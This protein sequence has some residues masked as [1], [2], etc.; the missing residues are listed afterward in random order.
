MDVVS[1][2]LNVLWLGRRLALCI[3][4]KDAGALYGYLFLA[5]LITRKVMPDFKSMIVNQN[6]AKAKLKFT[7]ASLRSHAE[8]IAFF[9]GGDR[10]QQLTWTHFQ[11]LLAAENQQQTSDLWFGWFKEFF[12][13][14]VPDRL[15]QHMRFKFAADTFDD[16]SILEDGGASLAEGQH[17]IGG[18]Q[19][20]VKNNI[21]SIIEVSDKFNNLSGVIQRLAELDCALDQ[22]PDPQ[23]IQQS[24][25]GSSAPKRDKPRYPRLTVSKLDIVTPTGNC[26]GNGINLN[27]SPKNRL[28]VTGPNAA[29]KTSFF[30]L[31]GGLWPRQPQGATIEFTPGATVLMVPQR[32]YSVTGTL[33]DQV[34]YPVHISAEPEDDAGHRLLEATEEKARQLLE[35]V[36]ITKLIGRDGGWHDVQKFEDV[37][38]LGEQQRL[39]M[40]RL[41]YH[42][43]SFAVLDECTDAVSKDVEERL[44]KQA[45][46]QGI[47]CI[48]ISKRLALEEFHEQELRL[49]ELSVNGCSVN[50]LKSH[51]Q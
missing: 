43:P 35:M 47:V 36:G 1:P 13:T 24:Q 15:Q 31:L 18:I 37:L 5:G 11:E 3:Q 38:S 19:E 49:G 39:G 22:L 46:E 29:G 30:R 20:N 10:E 48:T 26:L 27:I 50:P 21:T 34:T 4:G 9:A 41:F 32:C 23:F 2:V 16:S 12:V 51:K 40:A 45:I 17:V 44:Y 28:L 8:S 33:L 25:S 7:H 6:A 14:H 42:N